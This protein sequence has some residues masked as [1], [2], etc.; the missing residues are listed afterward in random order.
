LKLNGKGLKLR[1]LIDR[2]SIEVFADEGEV[3][4]SHVVLEP[5]ADQAASLNAEG[6]KVRLVAL[7]ASTLESIWLNHP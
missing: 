7:E 6:G 5:P 1:I 3:S 2:P 4:I